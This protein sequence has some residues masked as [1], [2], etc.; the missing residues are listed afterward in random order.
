MQR[1][2]EEMRRE[3]ADMRKLM[4]AGDGPVPAPDCVRER[5]GGGTEFGHGAVSRRSTAMD[6]GNDQQP[7]ASQQ[8]QARDSARG[9][10]AATLDDAAQ[11]GY[12]RSGQRSSSWQLRVFG[13]GLHSSSGGHRVSEVMFGASGHQ[14]QPHSSS[15]GHRASEVLMGAGGVPPT[16]SSSFG[17][18]RASEGVLMG[19]GS[20][21]TK[22]SSFGGGITLGV[23][24]VSRMSNPRGDPKRMSTIPGSLEDPTGDGGQTS[25]ARTDEIAPP[26]GEQKN[27]GEAFSQDMNKSTGDHFLGFKE[28]RTGTISSGEERPKEL[29]EGVTTVASGVVDLRRRS[30]PGGH[31]AHGAAG[32]ADDVEEEVRGHFL[33]GSIFSKMESRHKTVP[34][35][36]DELRASGGSSAGGAAA[37][38]PLRSSPVLTK[39]ELRVLNTPV[40][41]P[42]RGKQD[43]EGG[44]SSSKPSSRS[45]TGPSSEGPSS[46]G[47]PSSEGR[48]ISSDGGGPSSEGTPRLSTV[49]PGT[50]TS[51]E[52][53]TKNGSPV[54]NI[55][56]PVASA[57]ASN[58]RQGT[59]NK[60]AAPPSNIP[61]SGAELGVNKT[62]GSS[63]SEVTSGPVPRAAQ[64]G[65]S[66]LNRSQKSDSPRGTLNEE[67]LGRLARE[68]N[69][70]KET[71]DSALFGRAGRNFEILSGPGENIKKIREDEAGEL[72]GEDE[73][74]AGGRRSG[75]GA[76]PSQEAAPA[77]SRRS[78]APDRTGNAGTRSSLP[79]RTGD[80]V[81]GSSRKSQQKKDGP[82]RPNPTTVDVAERGT[83]QDPVVSRRIEGN[84]KRDFGKSVKS[85]RLSEI[86]RKSSTQ[87]TGSVP[88]SRRASSSQRTA[89]QQ[90]SRGLHDSHDP[91]SSSQSIRRPQ[92]HRPSQRSDDD[93]NSSEE[94]TNSPPEE[95]E[96]EGSPR[97]PFRGAGGSGQQSSSCSPPAPAP[98][99]PLILRNVGA[100]RRLSNESILS[101]ISSLSQ[102]SSDFLE[103]LEQPASSRRASAFPPTRSA[104]LPYG[105]TERR[106]SGTGR[107]FSAKETLHRSV[108][109]DHLRDDEDVDQG[110][111]Q[112]SKRSSID[113]SA[114]LRRKG[115]FAWNDWINPDIEDIVENAPSPVQGMYDDTRRMS[116]GRS[117]SRE[118]SPPE[119]SVS[120]ESGRAAGSRR[121][122]GSSTVKAALAHPTRRR[123]TLDEERPPGPRAKEQVD[124]RRTSRAAP[125]AHDVEDKK[126]T[127]SSAGVRRSKKK[128]L[129]RRVQSLEEH[130]Q[131]IENDAVEGSFAE[132][133]GRR[134]MLLTTRDHEHVEE[135]PSS[136]AR[137]HEDHSY[138][139][140][141]A[142]LQ[143][144]VVAPVRKNP[145]AR[146]LMKQAS[147]TWNYRRGSM[148]RLASRILRRASTE[149]PLS[150][151]APGV[152]KMTYVEVKRMSCQHL[153]SS[154]L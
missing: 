130:Q 53:I 133:R 89:S 143:E 34:R 17:P 109:A 61:E 25:V 72:R 97:P 152:S 131:C 98:E 45:P 5:L 44:G 82:P 15:G 116:K 43:V 37:V 18:H 149:H 56:A 29:F 144:E 90:S 33:A 87:E 78:S 106:R 126:K 103:D 27:N 46:G 58:S 125:A 47:R 147:K 62:G 42:P 65:P 64:E 94:D 122:S 117:A 146:P 83:R 20:S 13:G 141:G 69:I 111:L 60:Q 70:S 153:P 16:K 73:E 121:A 154:L 9:P 66:P 127:S 102:L 35:T 135:R 84:K 48:R 128:F 80:H 115:S 101:T 95:E 59:G 6:R 54:T 104:E 38:V 26:M 75:A 148:E 68:R 3:M 107:R 100:K 140:T 79:D 110:T 74:D 7:V 151:S 50:G 113:E 71:G 36:L 8:Q 63:T 21:P 118:H 1:E 85:R 30:V 39:D 51:A 31:A 119:R 150:I 112:H 96:E 52:E 99:S 57:L 12:Q 14:L 81:A 41:N 91:L 114:Y 11:R 134:P 129:P 10:R 55:P 142:G 105:R 120:R 4:T 145:P 124:Q 40:R 139:S 32:R 108:S 49:A 76:A 123:R 28:P 92:H 22:S 67:E 77:A 93:T 88:T 137:E 136:R 138:D 86:L 19:G 132:G 2:L 24:G 23:N